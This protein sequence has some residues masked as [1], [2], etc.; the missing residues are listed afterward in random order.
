MV[1]YK[2]GFSFHFI[3]RCTYQNQTPVQLQRTN[4]HL[5][6]SRTRRPRSCRLSLRLQR[7]S[8]VRTGRGEASPHTPP[9]SSHSWDFCDRRSRVSRGS[10]PPRWHRHCR[11]DA[12]HQTNRLSSTTDREIIKSIYILLCVSSQQDPVITELQHGQ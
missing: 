8:C 11:T 5:S 6:A 9:S 3:N 7:F 4:L 2:P 10:R 12:L 1:K